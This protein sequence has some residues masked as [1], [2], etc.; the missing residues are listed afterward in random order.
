[1]T[2]ATPEPDEQQPQDPYGVEERI[3]GRPPSGVPKLDEVIPPAFE[4]VDFDP[5]FV[6]LDPVFPGPENPTTRYLE[7]GVYAS[8]DGYQMWLWT[9]RASGGW[10]GIAL[11]RITFGKVKKYGNELYEEDSD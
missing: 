9:Q 7:D 2:T 11:D 4:V 5:D 6:P 8:H 10:V 3:S 1:M